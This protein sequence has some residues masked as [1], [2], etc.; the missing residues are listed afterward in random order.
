MKIAFDYQIF[1]LQARGGISRYFA[2]LTKALVEIHEDARIIAPL[3]QNHH[4][5][6]VAKEWTHGQHIPSITKNLLQLAEPLNYRLC[7]RMLRAL[8]PDIIHETYY[9]GRTIGDKSIPHIITIHDMI[10]E[11][12]PQEFSKRDPALNHKCQSVTK[13]D[14]IICV[15]ESTKRDLCDIFGTNP[16]K[17][18]V[19]YHGHEP[20]LVGPTAPPFPSR[21]HPY[22]LYVGNRGGYKNFKGMLAAIASRQALQQ[23]FDIIAFGGGSLSQS[24]HELIQRLGFDQNSVR[25]VQGNDLILA[26]LYQHATA[27]IYPSLYEGFGLPPLEA[28]GQNCPVISSFTSSMPEVI[29]DAGKYFDPSSIESQ[30]EAIESVVSNEALQKTLIQKGAERFRKYSWNNCARQTLDAY[31][32]T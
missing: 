24:E 3:H 20:P 17:I 2:Q 8:K 31:R 14:H 4:V 16:K 25:H 26:Q 27:L 23:N 7:N 30:A 19:I 29:G 9:T 21:P 11:R 22:L 6:E 18:S 1:S 15:S 32:D 5:M 13:A 10:Q 12:Y 28:M